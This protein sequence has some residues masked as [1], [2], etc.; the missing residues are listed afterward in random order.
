MLTN[1]AE[2]FQFL[3]TND[4]GTD[5]AIFYEA[6]ALSLENMG[7]YKDAEST[8]QLGINR[9]VTNVENLRIKFSRFTARMVERSQQLLKLRQEQELI[10]NSES[11]RR[12]PDEESSGVP[13]RES[14]RSSRSALSRIGSVSS[15]SSRNV[16]ENLRP[17]NSTQQSSRP[18]SLISVLSDSEIPVDTPCQDDFKVSWNEFAT[19]QES[20]KENRRLAV[21]WSGQ[22]L[23]QKSKKR[24]EVSKPSFSIYIDPECEPELPKEEET[25][26]AEYYKMIELIK[27]RTK[28]SQN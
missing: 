10:R 12:N 2:M 20:G 1:P 18:Q 21:G 26:D 6:Y 4:I 27:A 22:K 13:R 23:P 24:K 16:D 7:K 14:T 8:F 17:T 3:L 19:E 15:G 25:D 9:N 28:S 11:T 5:W